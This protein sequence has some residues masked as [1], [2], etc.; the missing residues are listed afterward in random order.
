MQKSKTEN[1]SIFSSFD[2]KLEFLM[3]Q[4]EL[5]QFLVESDCIKL[6]IWATWLELSWKCKQLDSI[7]IQVQ[8]VNLKLNLMISLVLSANHSQQIKYKNVL[9][10]FLL[11]RQRD[12]ELND[13]HK[14]F[15]L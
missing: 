11:L 10:Q 6:K 3:N 2:I 7:L 8:S 4:V 15:F 13:F 5:T 9:S 12:A 1:F 14:R